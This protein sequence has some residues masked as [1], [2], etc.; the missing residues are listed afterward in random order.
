[1]EV[2]GQHH[3]PAALHIERNLVPNEQ[4]TVRVQVEVWKFRR[5]EKLLAPTEIRTWDISACSLV[6][7]L[8]ALLQSLCKISESGSDHLTSEQ[9]VLRNDPLR[10]SS[11]SE[12]G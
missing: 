8:T 2:K 11:Q 5:R 1:V 7:I 9:K 3:T 12:W 10:E 6:I 4:E